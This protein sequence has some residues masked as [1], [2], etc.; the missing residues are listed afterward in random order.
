MTTT[1]KLKRIK[2]LTIKRSKWG[3]GKTGG[4]LLDKDTGLQ[5]CLGFAALASGVGADDIAGLCYP[6]DVARRIPLFNKHG[7]F[8]LCDTKLSSA[9]IN[10]NDDEDLKDAQREAALRKLFASN[11]VRVRFVP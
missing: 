9:A 6:R 8:G 4:A 3:R 10:V 1:R 2:T 7:R 5:C 11:G